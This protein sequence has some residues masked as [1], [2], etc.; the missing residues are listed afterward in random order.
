MRNAPHEYPRRILLAVTGLNPQV[1]TETLY[2]LAVRQRPAFVP[3]EVHL[4]TTA[5]G[6]QR[7]ELALLSEDPGWFHHLRKDYRLPEIAFTPDHIHVITDAAGQPLDDIRTPSDNER[8]ANLITDRVREFTRDPDTALHVSIAGGRKTMGFYL[9]YALSLFG[10]PQDRLSHVLVSEPYESSWQFFYPTPDSHVISTQGNRLVDTRDAEVEL[11]VIPFV[12]LRDGLDE[13]LLEG[14]A[15]FSETVAL[16]QR[17]LEPPRLVI[18]LENQCIL[19]A[20]ERIELPP[21]QLALLS[22]FAE[23]LIEGHGPVKAPSKGVPDA[24]W[25]KAFLEHYRAIRNGELDDIE[26]TERALRK[27]MDGEYF[28]ETKSKLHRILKKRLGAAAV[29]YLIDDGGTRPR[30]YALRLPR[31]AVCF[32]RLADEDAE[33]GIDQNR[34]ATEED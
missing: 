8:L 11:A 24:A 25:A 12:R 34:P 32:G 17:A 23:R 15:S 18:D 33:T 13:R 22:L 16:A 3:T 20:D 26:R 6:R 27:G 31:H 28:S 21:K 14:G 9:G 7:A 4:L 10:R 2:A 19:A 29:P 5:E 1:V 30:Q